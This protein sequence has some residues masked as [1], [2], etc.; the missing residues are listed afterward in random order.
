MLSFRSQIFDLLERPVGGLTPKRR[1]CHLLRYEISEKCAAF[2]VSP[3]PTILSQALPLAHFYINNV[4]MGQGH[5]CRSIW[6]W[7]SVEI[8]QDFYNKPSP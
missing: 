1:N 6:A 4:K 2:G 5:N 7:F 8:P 3:P